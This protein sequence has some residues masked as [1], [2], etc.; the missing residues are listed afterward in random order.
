MSKRTRLRHGLADQTSK[1]T[2]MRNI[3]FAATAALILAAGTAPS[4]AAHGNN[5]ATHAHAQALENNSVAQ[6]QQNQGNDSYS[7]CASILAGAPGY[8]PGAAAYCRS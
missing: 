5:G 3:I 7:R 1:E 8:P 6:A 4:L 2:I